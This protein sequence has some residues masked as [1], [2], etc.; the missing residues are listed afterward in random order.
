MVPIV[1]TIR[2]ERKL[3]LFLRNRSV[4]R[5]WCWSLIS[6]ADVC[7]LRQCIVCQSAVE[8]T[9]FLASWCP[10]FRKYRI[11]IQQTFHTW[12]DEICWHYKLL[13]VCE[14]SAQSWYFIYMML[15]FIQFQN[16]FLGWPGGSW[17][18][19]KIG[20]NLPIMFEKWMHQLH[21]STNSN[22]CV[23]INGPQ[24]CLLI[25]CS[26]VVFWWFQ[27]YQLFWLYRPSREK[28]G[29]LSRYCSVTRWWCSSSLTADMCVLRQCIVCQSAVEITWF[30]ASWCCSRLTSMKCY[31]D[32]KT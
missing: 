3:A 30:L 28:I 19:T 24:L 12:L 9:S 5:R 6:S 20:N 16:T 21:Y 11:V 17:R 32:E 10:L 1:R 22:L 27:L 29:T 25:T 13:S 7:V 26:L 2:L 18:F 8:I 14:F 4:T 15:A 31:Q 23:W